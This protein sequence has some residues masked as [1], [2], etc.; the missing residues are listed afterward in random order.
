VWVISRTNPQDPSSTGARLSS[1][2]GFGGAT[3]SRGF[4]KPTLEIPAR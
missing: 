3:F 4:D 2:Q 1:K